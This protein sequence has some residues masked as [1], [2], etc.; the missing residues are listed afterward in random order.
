MVAEPQRGL[1]RQFFA[2]WLAAGC[3][4]LACT[5]SL[6]G[7]QLKSWA[8]VA[9]WM[10]G[11]WQDAQIAQIDRLL[12]FS[13]QIDQHGRVAQ[14]N[15]WP[16]DWLALK[17]AAVLAN[18]PLDLVL[19][20]FE[21]DAFNHLFS[22]KKA[23]QQFR[24]TVIALSV[25]E[26]VAGVHLDFEVYTGATKHAVKNYQQFVK[27]LARQM[28]EQVP[29]RQLSVFYP[30]GGAFAL[31][32]PATLRQL[33]AV[34]FQGYDAHWLSG[35][36]AGPVAPLRGGY[37]LTWEK[38]D[39]L[40]QQLLLTET[41]SIIS[42]PLYGYEWPVK[43]SEVFAET[44]GSGSITTFAEMPKALLPDLQKSI[45]LRVEAYG[46]VH[47]PLTASAYYKF[48]P[49]PGEWVEGWFDDWWTLRQKMDFLC[50]KQH[51]GMAFFPL[52]YDR[53]E[54]LDFYIRRR[55]CVRTG[56]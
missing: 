44:K 20:L 16:E 53:N 47:D 51:S 54:L 37:G 3:L 34:V 22:N 33:H 40:R 14:A 15:G 9:H 48:S 38:I 21:V 46:A 36:R 19:T 43:G 56:D 4:L 27:E 32:E 1:M 39:L 8:Y 18:R 52:G 28:R 35:S 2:G 55:D 13:I 31:Y 23:I 6:A 25:E 24:D 50:Q 12:F 49:L 10:G 29:S 7:T 5:A 42:F 11:A 26:G 41:E 30:M 17:A 45:S